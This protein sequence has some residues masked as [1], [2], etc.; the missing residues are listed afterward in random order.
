MSRVTVKGHISRAQYIE[1]RE[2]KQLET[3]PLLRYDRISPALNNSV[4][5]VEHR[6]VVEASMGVAPPLPKKKEKFLA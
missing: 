1:A 5:S 2:K 6:C 4:S 3:F